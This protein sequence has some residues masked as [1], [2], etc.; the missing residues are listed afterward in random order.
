MSRVLYSY[1]SVYIIHRELTIYHNESPISLFF[2][3]YSAFGRE[4]RGA[5]SVSLVCFLLSIE[6]YKIIYAYTI[7]CRYGRPSFLMNNRWD[8]KGIYRV[9]WPRRNCLDNFLCV[10]RFARTRTTHIVYCNRS[11]GIAIRILRP[12]RKKPRGG[13]ETRGFRTCEHPLLLLLIISRAIY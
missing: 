4:T 6:R 11:W 8:E 5:I 3:S 2:Q 7:L 10:L 13:F 9:N 1:L 12:K